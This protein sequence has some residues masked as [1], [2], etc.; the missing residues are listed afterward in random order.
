MNPS[1]S[2]DNRSRLL[3]IDDQEQVHQAYR[4]VFAHPETDG[5]HEPLW[6]ES[7]GRCG[8][9][10][11]S[12]VLRPERFG[13]ALTH[14]K[15]GEEAIELCRA[16]QAVDQPFD[17]AFVD[18]RMPPGIDGFDTIERLWQ[19]DALLQ[20]VICTAFTDYASSQLVQ[21]FG[22]KDNLL[23]LKKPFAAEEAF[24]MAVS[25]TQKRRATIASQVHYEQLLYA[26]RGLANEIDHR[27]TSENRLHHAAT[28]DPLTGLPNRHYLKEILEARFVDEALGRRQC[29]ALIFLDIDDFKHIND[30][31]GHVVGD[32]LLVAVGQ[33]LHAR[34]Q[35]F[36]AEANGSTVSDLEG[37][38]HFVARMGGDE[39]VV[40]LSDLCEE[41]LAVDFAEAVCDDLGVPYSICGQELHLGCS[42]GVAFKSPATA[43]HE[44]LMGNADLAMYRAKLD[45]KRRVAVFDQEMRQSVLKRLEM[46]NALRVIVKNDELRLEY[47]PIID[48]QSGQIVSMES[49]ARWHHPQRGLISP[50]DF[51]SVAEETGQMN[52]IGRWVLEEACSAL[53]VLNRTRAP[54]AAISVSINVSKRQ[55]VD[56]AFVSML[57][58]VLGEQNLPGNLLNLEFTEALI[59]D[60]CDEMV[61]RLEEIRAL[62]VGLHLDNFGT[63]YC[64]LSCFHRFPVDVLKIHRS[65]VSLMES[66][67]AYGQVIQAIT[68]L[69]HNLERKVIAEGI[70]TDPQRIQLHDLKCDFGQGYFFSQ[71]QR[72][73]DLLTMLSEACSWQA[74]PACDAPRRISAW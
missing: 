9:D 26:N 22:Y 44:E 55:L 16:A 59:I 24:Q 28:H 7:L 35:T 43:T 68:S 21:R 42:L 23:L 17:V 66:D 64:S 60:N 70:E 48:M 39:F 37:P 13:F 40:F 10:K 47:Q 45:G 8:P 38:Q 32:Q 58:Q 57:Q 65:Y 34:L 54:E 50:A 67:P 46:E 18:M 6:A 15:Q 5:E 14:A 53:N 33:R 3:L 11:H 27:R 72:L 19:I 36:R 74:F 61:R 4:M 51:I 62:G 49:L 20:V 25:L 31:L 63:G 69:A 29:D 2:P 12:A 73:D 71:P 41:A 1:E 30:S 56:E 52:A